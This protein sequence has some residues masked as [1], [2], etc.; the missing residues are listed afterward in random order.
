VAGNAIDSAAGRRQHR[1]EEKAK[2]VPAPLKAVLE[3]L[4]K[5]RRLQAELPPLRGEDQRLRLV[6]TGLSPVDHLI[7]GFPRGQLSEVTGPASSGRSGL[8]LSLVARATARG[9]LC[10]WIDPADRFDPA[11]AETAGADLERLLWLRGRSS[12]EAVAAAGTLLGSGLFEAVVLDLASA[13]PAALRL[14]PGSTWIRLQRMAADTP[15]AL[16][17]LASEHVACGPGGVR[18]ALDGARPRWSGTGPGRLLRGLDA[19]V[20]AGRHAPRRAAFTLYAI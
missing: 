11:S 18:L 17:L 16:V 13:S 4:L 8:L 6:P 20:A 5:A 10:A 7:A 9:A 15:S 2:Q 1:S 19:T 3:D 14:L 12:N